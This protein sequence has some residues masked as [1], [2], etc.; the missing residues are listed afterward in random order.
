MTVKIQLN[1]IK[2]ESHFLE[3]TYSKSEVMAIDHTTGETFFLSDDDLSDI[4]S[5]LCMLR[6][7]MRYD[8]AR[9]DDSNEQ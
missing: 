1:N 6:K 3:L 7:R 2:E 5:A 4:I 9:F 8:K